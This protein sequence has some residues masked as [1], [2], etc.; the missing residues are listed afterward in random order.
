M[1]SKKTDRKV[2]Y[3]IVFL[4]LQV[5]FMFPPGVRFFS[6]GKLYLLVYSISVHL[7]AKA[8]WSKRWDEGQNWECMRSRFESHHAAEILLL[9]QWCKITYTLPVTSASVSSSEGSTKGPA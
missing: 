7:R 1:Q 8:D 2:D 6:V 4:S 3:N 5:R 9:S